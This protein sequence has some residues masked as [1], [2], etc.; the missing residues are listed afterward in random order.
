MTPATGNSRHATARRGD[1]TR[2]DFPGTIPPST[3]VWEHQ[4]AAVV[5][6]GTGKAPDSLLM[7][8]GDRGLPDFLTQVAERKGARSPSEFMEGVIWVSQREPE[9]PEAVVSGCEGLGSSFARFQHTRGARHA[10]R[11]AWRCRVSAALCGLSCLH[12]RQRGRRPS[13]HP[14]RHLKRRGILGW[15]HRQGFRNPRGSCDL[16]QTAPGEKSS[17]PALVP[18][19]RA[20]HDQVAWDVS[21]GPDRAVLPY[22]PGP[23]PQ[24]ANDV[25]IAVQPQRSLCSLLFLGQPVERSALSRDLFSGRSQLLLRR[26]G[27][28]SAGVPYR[29]LKVRLLRKGWK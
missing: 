20:S 23:E 4:K 27:S 24:Q 18:P 6:I 28:P 7:A 10:G 22:R 1:G 12:G 26:A 3:K 9:R 21:R 25:P 5:D 8:G 14:L 16:C 29:R 17:R 13:D 15:G 11:V 2:R 19:D